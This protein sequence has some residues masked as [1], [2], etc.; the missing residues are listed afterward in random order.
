MFFSVSDEVK[1]SQTYRWS[2]CSQ[3]NSEASGIHGVGFRIEGQN[4]PRNQDQYY[5]KNQGGDCTIV[6]SQVL[7][8]HKFKIKDENFR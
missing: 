4:K 8:C 6:K 5:F 3:Y 7:T 2:T 1:F